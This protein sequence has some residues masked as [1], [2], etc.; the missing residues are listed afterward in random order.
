M[1]STIALLLTACVSFTACS[2][3]RSKGWETALSTRVD[4]A[5]A[6]PAAAYA[7]KLSAALTAAGVEHKVVTYEFRYRTRLRED[8]IGT[9]TAVIYR[10]DSSARDPWWLADGNAGGPVWLPGHD[11]ER[12]LAFYMHR[13]A[14]VVS[15]D[16]SPAGGDGKRQL[17]ETAQPSLFARLWPVRKTERSRRSIAPQPAAPAAKIP[18][19][20]L[21]LFRA[22]HGSPFDP[23]SV[24][25]RVKMERLTHRGIAAR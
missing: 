8:A 21:A 15:V 10:D 14:T 23:A 2:V 24:V 6:D 25:D 22:R 17:A 19:R 18:P 16:G 4:T 9:R 11:L 20:Q 12:Q 7:E 13:P 1:R 3:R 5:D